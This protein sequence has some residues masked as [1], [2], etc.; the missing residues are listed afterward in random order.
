MINSALMS[1]KSDEWV[2][3]HWL[4]AA[5]NERFQFTVDAAATRENSL[6]EESFTNGLAASWAGERVWCNPPYSQIARWA[7]KFTAEAN[8]AALIVALVLARVDTRWYQRHIAKADLVKFIPGRLRFSESKNSA[9]FPSA[10]AFWFGLDAIL[11][12]NKR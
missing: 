6:C 5:L 8:H 12:R 2:T 7:E 4:F 10:L 1:S 9:P 3:P 11:E